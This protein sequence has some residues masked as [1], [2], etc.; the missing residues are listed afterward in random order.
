MHGFENMTEFQVCGQ[1]DEQN[2]KYVIQYW[3][4][5]ND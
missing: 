1:R 5:K 2:N 3:T 4:F